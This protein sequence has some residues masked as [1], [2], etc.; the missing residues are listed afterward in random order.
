MLKPSS[1]QACSI[2]PSMMLPKCPMSQ[3]VSQKQQ[4]HGPLAWVMV[5]IRCSVHGL[6]AP[7]IHS[8]AIVWGHPLKNLHKYFVRDTDKTLLYNFYGV[9]PNFCT[10]LYKV[11]PSPGGWILI[12]NGV[13]PFWHVPCFVVLSQTFRI[14]RYLLALHEMAPHCAKS[15]AQLNSMSV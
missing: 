12:L 3:S 4:Q 6:S 7:R 14:K 5:M 1:R 13:V 8:R 10:A 15:G 11:D 9:T 2:A